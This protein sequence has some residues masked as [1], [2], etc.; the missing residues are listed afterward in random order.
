MK[1]LSKRV[2]LNSN[3]DSASCYHASVIIK[4]VYFT[5]DCGLAGII[6]QSYRNASAQ[7][8]K[9]ITTIMDVPKVCLFRHAFL[10][11][12]F[13][14]IPHLCHCFFVYQTFS[15]SSFNYSYFFMKSYTPTC[16]IKLQSA[17]ASYNRANTCK[18]REIQINF[19]PKLLVGMGKT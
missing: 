16:G 11:M 6:F 4:L 2:Y 7:Q 17:Q 1:D 14:R 19:L 18:N 15:I 5:N 10:D 8:Y 12:T 3:I 9:V 13:Y